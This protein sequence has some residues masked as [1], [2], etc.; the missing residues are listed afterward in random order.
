MKDSTR[1]MIALF[2]GKGK[3]LEVMA[4]IKC[5]IGMALDRYLDSTRSE[6]AKALLGG[7][8]DYQECHTRENVK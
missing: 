7:R 6:Y 4:M 8:K 3:Q 5:P 1:E 2:A